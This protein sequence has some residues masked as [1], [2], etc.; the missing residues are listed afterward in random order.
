MPFGATFLFDGSHGR[1]AAQRELDAK[2]KPWWRFD[3]P[4]H[5]PQARMTFQ[6]AKDPQYPGDTGRVT[7]RTCCETQPNLWG[8]NDIQAIAPHGDAQ[9]H[10]EFMTMGR[11]DGTDTEN[12]DTDSACGETDYRQACYFNSGVFVQSRYEV[13]IQAIPLKATGL[14]DHSFGGIAHD[15][16]PLSNQARPNGVWQ[17]YDITF[18]TARYAGSASVSNGYMTVW[19]NGVRTHLNREVTRDPGAGVANHSGENVNDTL[20]GLKLQD[21]LGDVRFRNV[22]IKR[23]KIDSTGTDFGY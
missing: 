21:E 9:I 16:P 2:W 23:L 11:Y 1:A 3:L 8:Y 20:Y 10:V 14:G 5:P 17:A 22:W 15:F 13:Q 18:R 19:W 12:P 4:G 7:L 6:V